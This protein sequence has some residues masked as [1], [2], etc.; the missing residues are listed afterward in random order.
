MEPLYVLMHREEG[1]LGTFTRLVDAGL[2]MRRLL[3]DEPSRAG[4]LWI[5]SCEGVVSEPSEQ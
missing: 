4:D 1:R 3:I 5:E 2:E